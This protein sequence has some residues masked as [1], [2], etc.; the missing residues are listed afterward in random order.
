MLRLAYRPPYDGGGV[1]G[2]F[3]RGARCRA[4]SASTSGRLALWRSLRIDTEGGRRGLTHTGWVAVKLDPARAQVEL[5]LSASLLPV[6][7]RVIERARHAL[8][9]DAEP[10]AMAHVLADVPAP[11]I[12]GLR[13][14]G[15]F[16]PFETLVRIILGQQVT[17]AAARTLA[18]RVVE[19]FGETIDDAPPGVQR[20]VP[21]AGAAGSSR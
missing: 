10:Q 12:E 9:L 14:P 4:S 3:W 5:R 11:A 16:D 7:G 8:D 6:T 1:H 19:R 13:V 15:S 21:I 18:L 17:V 20:A 2:A